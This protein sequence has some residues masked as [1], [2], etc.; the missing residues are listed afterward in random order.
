[1]FTSKRKR[2]DDGEKKTKAMTP[3]ERE[4]SVV[5]S[6]NEWPVYN[7]PDGGTIKI[8]PWGSLRQFVNPATGEQVTK[9][10]DVSFSDYSFQPLQPSPY[11]DMPTTPV[12]MSVSNRSSPVPQ[13]HEMLVSPSCEVE[14]YVINGYNFYRAPERSDQF[15]Q[16]Q[17]NYLGMMDQDE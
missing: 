6:S 11:Y 14:S 9:F 12:S 3:L 8:T 4:H 2:D 7:H 16:E 15:S 5:T 13:P 17:E 1:M 10:E